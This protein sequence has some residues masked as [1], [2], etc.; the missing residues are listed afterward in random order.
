[1]AN[2]LKVIYIYSLW[3]SLRT[4]TSYSPPS[5]PSLPQTHMYSQH[6]CIRHHHHHHGHSDITKK[7][8]VPSQTRSSTTTPSWWSFFNSICCGRDKPGCNLWVCTQN[9]TNHTS[10]AAAW[11]EWFIRRPAPKAQKS[12]WISDCSDIGLIHEKLHVTVTDI[13]Y[14]IRWPQYWIWVM[15]TRGLLRLTP[16]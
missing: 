1:M 12:I 9:R 11:W 3:M 6:V 7:H 13:S 14:I 10:P 8:L 4:L 16:H 5:P 15:C 2:T